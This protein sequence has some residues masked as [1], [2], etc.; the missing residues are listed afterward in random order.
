MERG[1]GGEA[2]KLQAHHPLCPLELTLLW[3]ELEFRWDLEI[4]VE[5]VQGTGF[6]S[7]T[8]LH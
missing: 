6:S 3:G 5:N 2:G 7:G 4:W 1:G 8:D